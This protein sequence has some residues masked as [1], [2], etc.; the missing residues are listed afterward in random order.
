MIDFRYHLVS[1]I[2]VFLALAVGI[3]LGAGPLKEAI[4]DTLT[5]EV[6]ALRSRAADLRA[7]AD[8]VSAELARTNAAFDEAGDDLL[9]DLLGARNVAIVEIGGVHP[10]VLTRVG[11][12]IEQAGGAITATVHVEE[13]WIDPARRAFR[14]SIAGTLADYLDPEPTVG[15][16]V[17]VELAEALA[18]GL[19]TPVPEEP[20]ELAESAGAVLDVLV[21]GGLIRVQQPVTAP[22]DAV[23]MLV[24]PG[25]EPVEPGDDAEVDA[26]ASERVEAWLVAG[27]ELAVATQVR[28]S[29]LVVAGV[30]ARDGG[31][32]ADL[33][34]NV[35]TVTRVS[36]VSA[37]DTVSGELSVP[38]ALA[39]RIAGTVGQFGP[40]PDA[41][42][43]F[44]S[45]TV[46]APIVRVP[47]D[48]V[49]ETDD[50][51]T[52]DDADGSDEEAT[53]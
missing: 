52:D 25:T 40:E 22:A 13:A 29:G 16:G 43:A 12:R 47:V 48:P 46:L 38:T 20:K 15:S 2:S 37:V 19:T 51:E 31:L 33:R 35:R 28:S 53:G 34:S 41:T 23:V 17:E 7:E 26:E 14:Q 32:L 6:E 24:G 42:A 1:L 45:R 9:A 39:S 5:G 30:D 18:Q 50:A 44:P 8:A 10:T 4:G 49:D 21:E 3:V 11:E 36:T 27:V